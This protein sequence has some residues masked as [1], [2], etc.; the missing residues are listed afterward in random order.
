MLIEQLSQL[1]N[2]K[3]GLF[4]CQKY[5]DHQAPHVNVRAFLR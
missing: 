1:R 2:E 5:A 4:H 3:K